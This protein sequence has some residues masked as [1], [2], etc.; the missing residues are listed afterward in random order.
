MSTK[1]YKQYTEVSYSGR[2]LLEE[3]SLTET[4]IWRI[5]G[6]DPNCDFGGHHYQPDLGTVEGTLKDVIEY[7]V[8]LRSFWQWGAG[9][10]I[11]KEGA[12]K[13][14]TPEANAKRK[15]IEDKILELE[16]LLKESREELKGL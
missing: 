5:Y 6:E 8:E 4:G 10:R 1:N 7:A 9:G 15:A 13:K 14:I 11:V 16:K 12:P 2:K 3:H